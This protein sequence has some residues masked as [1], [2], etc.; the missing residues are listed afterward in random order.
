MKDRVVPIANV[1]HFAGRP[2]AAALAA[3]GATVAGSARG[4][5]R[6][7]SGVAPPVWRLRRCSGAGRLTKV[8]P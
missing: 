8:V 3:Q 6:G 2:V 1:E 5:R 4:L 7:A